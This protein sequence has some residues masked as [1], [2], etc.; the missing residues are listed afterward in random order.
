MA[1]PT[2]L[3]AAID[4]LTQYDSALTGKDAEVAT[5]QAEASSI[6]EARNKARTLVQQLFDKHFPPAA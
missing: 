5:K 6:R 1:L 4:D 3:Q 2:D